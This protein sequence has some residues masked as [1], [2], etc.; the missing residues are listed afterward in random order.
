MEVQS[1]QRPERSD[2]LRQTRQ[3]GIAEIQPPQGHERSD[4]RRQGRKIRVAEGQLLQ[5]REGGDALRQGRDGRV[6]QIQPPQGAQPPNLLRQ[7]RKLRA[8]QIQLLQA[9]QTPKRLRQLGKAVVGEIQALEPLHPADGPGNI[10]NPLVAQQQLLPGLQHLQRL[11]AGAAAPVQLAEQLVDLAVGILAL[12]LLL[13][14]GASRLS[15]PLPGPVCLFVSSYHSAPEPV[16]PGRRKIP[17]F[18]G[19]ERRSPGFFASLLGRIM[20]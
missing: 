11:R 8:A 1:F 7:R 20:V 19:V 16:K 15:P 14:H 3:A 10:L 2:L 5:R 6:L 9:G 18:F 4:A 13:C 17:V 12:K